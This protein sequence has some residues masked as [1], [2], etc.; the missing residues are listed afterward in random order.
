MVS[1]TFSSRIL[2]LLKNEISIRQILTE[3][4]DARVTVEEHL[5]KISIK[6]G[7]AQDWAE[8]SIFLPKVGEYLDGD[9]GEFDDEMEYYCIKDSISYSSK[10]VQKISETLHPLQGQYEI[11][12]DNSYMGT[13]LDV[14]TI[15]GEII[16]NLK[17]INGVLGDEELPAF[18]EAYV[19]YKS[20][21]DF[22]YMAELKID[23]VVAK[24]QMNL[25][26]D[27][28]ALTDAA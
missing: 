22:K 7:D 10:Y 17:T 20:N 23:D 8:N 24:L 15:H 16:K 13:V 12:L 21:D 11:F 5:G 25:L 18:R 14:Y 26:G 28:S 27:Y 1:K 6:Y 19:D 2:K 9:P 3:N 4:P